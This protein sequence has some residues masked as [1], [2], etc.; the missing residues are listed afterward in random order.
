MGVEMEA[1]SVVLHVNASKRV[2]NVTAGK[3]SLTA[4]QSINWTTEIIY[5]IHYWRLLLAIKQYHK[6]WKLT[7]S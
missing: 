2:V 5:T 4:G 7:S 6:Y 1:S 3:W